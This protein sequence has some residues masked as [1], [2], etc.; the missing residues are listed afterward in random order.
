MEPTV[1][2]IEIAGQA[3]PARSLSPLTP[4]PT[5]GER[6]VAPVEKHEA[7]SEPPRRVTLE[8]QGYAQDSPSPGHD[9]YVIF[10]KKG[11]S[12]VSPESCQLG[13]ILATDS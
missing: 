7:F 5:L 1:T 8:D 9:H 12:W 6:R 3:S 10:L 11:N 4:A 13:S 2:V